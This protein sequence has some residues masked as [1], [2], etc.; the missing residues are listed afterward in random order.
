MSLQNIRGVY[1]KRPWFIMISTNNLACLYTQSLCDKN[2]RISCIFL[3][4]FCI[5]PPYFCTQVINHFEG[6]FEEIMT[7]FTFKLFLVSLRTILRSK[8]ARAPQKNPR[9]YLVYVCFAFCPNLV[10]IQT[11]LKILTFSCF[12]QYVGQRYIKIPMH[13]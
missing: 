5:W 9:K 10:Y 3:V 7:L 13:C 1:P 4:D 6:F 11:I 2:S 12:Y 8:K